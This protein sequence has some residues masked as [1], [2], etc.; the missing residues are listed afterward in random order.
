MLEEMEQIQINTELVAVEVLQLRVLM[1]QHLE[2]VV[3]VVQVH[4]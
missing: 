1:V 3:R 4:F 2:L